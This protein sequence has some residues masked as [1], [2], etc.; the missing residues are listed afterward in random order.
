MW[1]L[2]SA[3]NSAIL[4]TDFYETV[5][6]VANKRFYPRLSVEKTA[7]EITTT[8]PSFGSVPEI[9][10]LSG[11]SGG[12]AR[13]PVP[14]KDWQ[15]AATVFEW[16]QT[17]PLTRLVAQSK[18]ESV[19]S[20]TTQLA[21]K[22]M[23]GMDAVLCQALVSTTALGYDGVALLSASH[24]ESGTN[25]SNL[26]TGANITTNY[27]PTGA[28]A[29]AMLLSA[30]G[31]MLAVVD[32][33][34]TPVNEG[35]DRFIILC[36]PPMEFPFLR[37]VDPTMSNMAVDSSGGTGVFR[38]KFE[39]ITSAYATSTGLVGGTMDRIFVFAKDAFEYALALVK[40]ADWQFNTNI[41]NESSDDWNN[42]WGFLR[43][44]AAF[45]YVPW[46]WQS[47]QCHIVT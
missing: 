8:F 23:K 28:E 41:G 34:G 46:Q 24:P 31:L 29:E 40:L 7:Q 26:T 12:G 5:E 10:Q 30:T 39:V 45:A 22:A 33:Q 25:Q 32:D 3:L 27:V 17:V 1:P 18:P 44:W 20:K 16:A 14:L 13:Q 35:L 37:I 47:V 15:V 2:N 19:R 42:G 11:I 9:K 36:P 4:Q 21:Q 43:S 6:R 38:G